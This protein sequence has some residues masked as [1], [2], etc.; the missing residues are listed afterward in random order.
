MIIV[1]LFAYYTPYLSKHLCRL[2]F[3]SRTAC[4]WFNSVLAFVCPAFVW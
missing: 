4:L 3:N 2:H 1:Q